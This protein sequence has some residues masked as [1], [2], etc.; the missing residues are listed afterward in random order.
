MDLPP[1]EIDGVKWTIYEI[2]PTVGPIFILPPSGMGRPFP[3]PGVMVR[4]RA[5]DGRLG[6]PEV[7]AIG[8]DLNGA[9]HR[10]L[11]TLGAPRSWL[12]D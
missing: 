7:H 6:L 8:I 10:I 9:L 1:F 4:V 12:T 5:T 3:M 11:L 2:R